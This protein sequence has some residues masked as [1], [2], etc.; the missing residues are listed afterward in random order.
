LLNRHLKYVPYCEKYTPTHCFFGDFAHWAWA[1]ISKP[2]GTI[3]MLNN[4][5]NINKLKITILWKNGGI[6]V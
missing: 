3:S 1:R 6:L 5:K 2:K 4:V